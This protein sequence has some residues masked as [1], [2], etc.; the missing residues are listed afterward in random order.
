MR[1]EGGMEHRRVELDPLSN[2]MR[3]SAASGDGNT[4]YGEHHMPRMPFATRVAWIRDVAEKLDKHGILRNIHWIP[5]AE[6]GCS[7]RSYSMD[8]TVT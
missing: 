4:D 5:P 2:R 8:A 1:T 6:F 7:C 3:R